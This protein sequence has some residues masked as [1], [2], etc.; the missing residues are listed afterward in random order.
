M[1]G[2]IPGTGFYDRSRQDWQLVEFKSDATGAWVTCKLE[3]YKNPLY[4]AQWPFAH[5]ITM[6][7]RVSE[8]ALEVRTR[9]EGHTGTVSS[10]DWRGGVLVSGSYDTTVRIWRMS[11]ATNNAELGT[12]ARLR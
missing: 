8:G 12:P 11:P 5:T 10:L 4:M 1:R 7:F 3:F 9:L 6:T 2:P